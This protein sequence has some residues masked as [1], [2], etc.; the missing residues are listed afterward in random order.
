M[1]AKNNIVICPTCGQKIV[2]YKHSLNRTLISCLWRLHSVG[3]RAR[4]DEMSLNNTEF[5]NF[6]KLRYFGLAMPTGSHNEWILTRLGLEF[7]RAQRKV[8]KFVFT[9]NAC[10]VMHSV[11]LV[12]VQEIKDC[13]SFRVEWQEQAAQPSLFDNTGGEQ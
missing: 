9:Q 4:L 12:F 3:G 2:R 8:S 6:Q 10:V 5:T 13:V 11:E 1:M 7:L